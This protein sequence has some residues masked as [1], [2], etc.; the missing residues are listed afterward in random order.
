MSSE[1]V[2]K[3]ARSICICDGRN[4]DAHF[5]G[6]FL[7]GDT[8]FGRETGYSPWATIYMGMALNAISTMREP[9]LT[10]RMA[11]EHAM[12]RQYG[13][14]AWAHPRPV[15]TSMI[16]AALQDAAEPAMRG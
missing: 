15:W 2:L 14:E 5:P 3:V 6:H 16:D 4:P 7:P 12:A 10:M 9:S 1:M 11:G 8:K 13:K